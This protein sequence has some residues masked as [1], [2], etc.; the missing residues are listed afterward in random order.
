MFAA[1]CFAHIL[2]SVDSLYIQSTA[3]YIRASTLTH[4]EHTQNVKPEIHFIEKD[5][6]STA[7]A[8]AVVAFACKCECVSCIRCVVHFVFFFLVFWFECGTAAYELPVCRWSLANTVH[9]K[10]KNQIET[11]HK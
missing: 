10:R 11:E 1:P 3:R 7:A 6:Q 4:V 2:F 5:I 9:E 8:A